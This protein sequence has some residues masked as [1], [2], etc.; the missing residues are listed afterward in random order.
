MYEMYELDWMDGS[1]PLVA[2]YQGED[3]RL[4]AFRTPHGTTFKLRALPPH[5]LWVDQELKFVKVYMHV[6]D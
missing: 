2:E 4:H 5:G 6:P 1:A 3:R